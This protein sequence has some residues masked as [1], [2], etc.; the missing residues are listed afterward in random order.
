MIL[1]T[2]WR[3]NG[4]MNVEKI[5]QLALHAISGNS[6]LRELRLVYPFFV[7]TLIWYY[8]RR[9]YALT[10]LCRRTVWIMQVFS[11]EIRLGGHY[12]TYWIWDLWR[13]FGNSNVLNWNPV[14]YF[15][16][17][18]NRV[19]VV[20]SRIGHE[21]TLFLGT[22]SKPSKSF[23]SVE[24]LEYDYF[25]YIHETVY[26]HTHTRVFDDP[27]VSPPSTHAIY[28]HIHHQTYINRILY[29]NWGACIHSSAYDGRLCVYIP[30]VT[31][32]SLT[33]NSFLSRRD[34]IQY[35]IC[36]NWRVVTLVPIPW[37]HGERW[38]DTR[39]QVSPLQ[40]RERENGL[41]LSC[42]QIFSEWVLSVLNSMRLAPSL[43]GITSIEWV[44]VC[45]LCYFSQ[46]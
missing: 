41:Y 1:S 34:L 5:L 30:I 38:V 12:A 25:L 15:R 14:N 43:T 10:G 26:E 17:L 42:S 35:S 44:D 24:A 29:E 36:Y 21:T 2:L 33:D 6:K 23:G 20:L 7:C 37:D 28:H 8:R 45:S 46:K 27:I 40:A 31:I 9:A 4:V 22:G 19:I 39:A 18:P 13:D 16:H 32:S 3:L 11:L